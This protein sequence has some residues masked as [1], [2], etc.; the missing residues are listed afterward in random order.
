MTGIF[1][2]SIWQFFIAY[3]FYRKNK[4]EL[5]KAQFWKTVQSIVDKDVVRTDRSHPYFAGDDNPNV[6]VMRYIV[7]RKIMFHNA[8]SL[9]C[10][11]TISLS[12]KPDPRSNHF[13]ILMKVFLQRNILLNYATYNHEVGYN[14]GMSD[15]LASVLAIVQDEV[16]AFWCFV[17]LIEG[18]VFVTP[19]KDDV[20]D[21]QLVS[22]ESFTSLLF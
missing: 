11:P 4:S 6:A 14:Q 9:L 20:M 15:L 16:D 21:K 13:V 19:P 3:L 10:F 22:K 7:I 2:T 1:F 12:E 5:E 17:G 18:S 8:W